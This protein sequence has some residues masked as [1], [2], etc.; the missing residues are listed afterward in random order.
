[1]TDDRLET[2]TNEELIEVIKTL[3]QA[4]RESQALAETSG[5]ASKQSSVETWPPEKI[6]ERAEKVR[7]LCHKEIKKQMK[8]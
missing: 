8:W 4:L 3:Q 7:E 1:M 6:A 5:N 2:T